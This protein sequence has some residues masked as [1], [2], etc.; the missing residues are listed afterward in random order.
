MAVIILTPPL[1]LP[2]ALSPPPPAPHL[3]EAVRPSHPISSLPEAGIRSLTWRKCIPAQRLPSH[4][5]HRGGGR[6]WAGVSVAE[7]SVKGCVAGRQAGRQGRGREARGWPRT[8]TSRPGSR[9]LCLPGWASS[10]LG[11]A[12][13]VSVEPL[14]LAVSAHY[15]AHPSRSPAR[16]A[17][18][19][20]CLR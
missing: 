1:I 11:A 15:P 7:G 14:S 13:Q 20:F 10:M 2:T 17:C 16:P 6:G 9:P 12:Y 3:E 5:P 19:Q 4:S 18:P 8:H